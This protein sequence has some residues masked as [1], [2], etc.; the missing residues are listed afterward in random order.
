MSV[1][2]MIEEKATSTTIKIKKRLVLYMIVKSAQNLLTLALVTNIIK[3][4]ANKN[5]TNKH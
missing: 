2:T 3:A 4:L 1:V 5:E